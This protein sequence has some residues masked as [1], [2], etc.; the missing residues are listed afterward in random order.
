MTCLRKYLEFP[1]SS[2][3]IDNVD[4]RKI[5]NL[6]V[7]FIISLKKRDIGFTAIRNYVSA[8]CKYYRTN[9]V[10]LNTNKIY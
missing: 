7:D 8:I 1:G 2:K 4:S 9:D 6:I 3:I 10:I 5:D